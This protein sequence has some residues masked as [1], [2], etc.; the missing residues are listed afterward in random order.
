LGG[1][2]LSEALGDRIVNAALSIAGIGI[3]KVELIASPLIG[4]ILCPLSLMVLILLATWTVMR[5]I[6][7]YNIISFI[8][9]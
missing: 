4:Y 6:K 8:N 7:K 9:E 2:I 1:I 3:K 5:T